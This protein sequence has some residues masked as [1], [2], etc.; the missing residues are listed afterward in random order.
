MT[1]KV[2]AKIV[3]R[4]APLCDQKTLMEELMLPGNSDNLMRVVMMHVTKQTF[5]CINNELAKHFI[6]S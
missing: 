6:I 3:F 4:H 2:T 5:I 1:A